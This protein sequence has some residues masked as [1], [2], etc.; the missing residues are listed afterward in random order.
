MKILFRLCAFALVALPAFAAEPAAAPSARIG[1][2]VVRARVAG[3]DVL[4]YRTGVQN[5]VT[6]RG[7][8]PAGDRFAAGGNVAIAT[9]VG[10]LLDKGTTQHDKFA[11]ADQLE[12]VGAE[13]GFS[14]GSS[15]LEFSGKC[16]KK[17]LPLVITLLA[18][19]LRTPAFAPEEL[20]KLK[21]QLAGY[22]QRAMES[23]D[24]RA[25]QKFS[26]AIYPPGH[27]NWQP[28]TEAMLAGIKAATIDDVKAFHAKYYGP[29]QCTL[30][31]VGDVDVAALQA[32]VGKSF[33]GWTGGVKL[34]D[35][36]K[37]PPTD[38][39]R[40]QT[41]F[42]PDKTSVTVVWGQSTGL[43]YT[44]P[45]RLALRVGTAI[46]G[47]GFTGRLMA[48]VRDKEGLTYGIGSVMDNDTFTDGDWQIEATFAPDLL[49]KGLASTQRE[50]TA[51]YDQGV[52]AAELAHRK[53]NLAGSYKVGLAT[54]G[55][56]A[57]QLLVTV[58]RGLDVTWLDEYPEK[59][60]TL[61]PE[62]VNGAIK[63]HLKPDNM[64]LIEAGTVP[65]VAPKKP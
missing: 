25:G 31:V 10:E 56:L 63:K 37:A 51:W 62:Q 59:I 36:A 27:P 49:D 5:V 43:R 21:Q 65:G 61:T 19:Q 14:T 54:T 55:G 57:S 11:I 23:T 7:S 48:N 42:M 8:L 32:E 16:L 1:Q 47:S 46:L 40:A 12:S 13:I 39:A 45:D 28:P 34:E 26:E 41:V 15:M 33:A 3:L 2:N 64:V 53:T 20:A 22:F 44:D 6:F 18:E 4:A 17:D 50:L 30:V 60:A 58:Q 9:L 24:Y 35:A 52:T 38:T 29:A